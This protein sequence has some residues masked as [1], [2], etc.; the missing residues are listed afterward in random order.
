MKKRAFRLLSFMFIYIYILLYIVFNIW[1][2]V[3]LAAYQIVN[4]LLF[5]L[6]VVYLLL[7]TYYVYPVHSLW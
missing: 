4:L 1:K 3:N 5:E 6:S 2:N 7:I